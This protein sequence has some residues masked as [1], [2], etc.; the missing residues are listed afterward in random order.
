MHEQTFF[1]DVEAGADLPP[2]PKPVSTRKLVKYAGA[3]RDFNEIHYDQESTSKTMW[4]QIIVQGMLK[5]GCMAQLATDFMGPNGLLLRMDC[6]YRAPDFANQTMTVQGH[7]I[8]KENTG[9]V[10]LVHCDATVENPEGQA[11]T[12]GHFTVALPSRDGQKSAY[13]AQP[14]IE[15]DKTGM[16]KGERWSMGDPDVWTAHI[17]EWWLPWVSEVEQPWIT[18]FS[19][20]I[21]DPNPLYSDPDY[22]SS[23]I[24]E[25]VVAPPTFVESL[26]ADW[27]RFELD[28]EPLLEASRRRPSRTMGGGDGWCDFNW[29]ADIHPGDV[30]SA[31]TRWTE[32][33]EKTG[34]SG[35]LLFT[36]RESVIENQHGQ[37]VSTSKRAT[38]SVVRQ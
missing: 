10:G 8:S 15:Y 4:G 18:A 1:E 20:A 32:P 37:I 12:L 17:G 14:T 34:R 5:A 28:T 16:V 19:A 2:L 24:R 22:A 27:R 7:V 35:K 31:Y 33:Y 9:D 26:D 29:Y 30:M 21:G 6:T 11:T 13:P 23:T 38:V 36:T 3:S 25:D